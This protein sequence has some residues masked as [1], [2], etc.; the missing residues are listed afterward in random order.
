MKD[1]GG[2]NG[3]KGGGYSSNDW[4]CFWAKHSHTAYRLMNSQIN[5]SVVNWLLSHNFL[6]Q[7]IN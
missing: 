1:E 2:V 6:V 7:P 3:Y 4:R 5:F